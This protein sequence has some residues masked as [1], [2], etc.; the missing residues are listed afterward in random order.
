LPVTWLLLALL[1]HDPITTKITW[2]AEISRIVNRRCAS[3]HMAGS[4][5]DLSNYERARPWAKAIRNQVLQRSMPPWG[6]V[7]GFGDFQNDPS[8]TPLEIEMITQW[9]EG[10]APEGDPAF[11]PKQAAL[12]AAAKLQ[13]RWSHLPPVL[14]KPKKL[15]AVRAS[16]PTELSA[17][18][19]DGSVE[20]LLWIRDKQAD[21]K[22]PYIF[23]EP[24]DLP[25]GTRLQATGAPVEIS[26]AAR[27]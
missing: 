22:Q 26:V 13:L 1:A 10:G 5:V 6:A 15:T 27:H 23:R 11:L 18:L 20:H 17:V 2:D 21:W 25:A 16:G 3:C 19:P 4:A 9:V 24:I 8:L 12:E 7:K 14:P